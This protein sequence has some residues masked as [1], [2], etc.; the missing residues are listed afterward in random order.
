MAKITL[1]F[2]NGPDPDVTPRVLDTLSKH[3]VSA[4]FFVIGSKVVQGPG[5][6]L[7]RR[8]AKEGHWVGNHTWSHETPFG[9]LEDPQDAIAEISRTQEVIQALSHSDKFF[10]PFGGGGF[11]DR[12]LLNS[13]AVDF[14]CQEAYTC[15]TWNNVPRDWE[16]PDQW[17]RPALETLSKQRWSVLVVHDFVRP[18]MD[19]LSEFIDRAKDLGNNFVLGF[20]EECVPI[21]R[22]RIMA[23]LKDWMPQ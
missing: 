8:V 17:V 13:Q 15:V 9:E 7:V 23:D 1:T 3:D 6:D 19:H 20:P 10:R 12:R 4:V 21:K 5:L 14:L 22:G 11:L 16:R 18:S 2:D